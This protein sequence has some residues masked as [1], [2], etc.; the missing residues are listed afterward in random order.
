MEI[1][2]LPPQSN[3]FRLMSV[4]SSYTKNCS[5]FFEKGMWAFWLKNWEELR[6]IEV[7]T[8]ISNLYKWLVVYKWLV[9]ACNKKCQCLLSNKIKFLTNQKEVAE[10]QSHLFVPQMVVF[11]VVEGYEMVDQCCELLIGV[12][13]GLQILLGNLEREDEEL[14]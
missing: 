7:S 1:P 8:F 11:E 4:C 12:P 10:D 14:Q 2:D 9:D 5:I 3:T 6:W 13:L